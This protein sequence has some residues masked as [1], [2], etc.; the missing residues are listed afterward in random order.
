MCVF[1]VL[2]LKYFIFCSLLFFQEFCCLDPLV[3]EKP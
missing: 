1:N 3:L 2:L